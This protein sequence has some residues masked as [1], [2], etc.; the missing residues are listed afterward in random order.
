MA[1]FAAAR[2]AQEFHFADRERREIV[3][4]HEALERFVLEK[5]I[6]ALL[7][8]LGAERGG[9]ERLRLAAGEKRRAV[10]ARQHADFAGDLANLVEGAGIGT[11]AANQHVVAEDALAKALE[12]AIGELLLVFVFFGDRGQDF[13]LD[14]VN[15]AVA[16]E[17]RDASRCRARRAGVRRT[18]AVICCVER[19]VE[20]GRL[21]CDFRLVDA[22]AEILDR[23][24]DLLDG[25]VAEFER[26][27]DG[28]F[29]NFER[30][31]FHHHD[32]FARSR[33]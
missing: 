2:A 3:V 33:R 15:Q 6:E 31:R 7:V 11:A 14:R 16:F 24:D 10:N 8:F 25:G 1:D 4:Q 32:R 17:L 29:G 20:G 18:F 27:G 28:V 9:G 21:D 13:G 26:V 30:A 12:G 23:G 19:F 5:Q 22:R